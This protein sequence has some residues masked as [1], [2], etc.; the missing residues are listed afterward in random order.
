MV[1]CRVR[2]VLACQP[3]L[4]PTTPPT[5]RAVLLGVSRL[6]LL[7]IFSTCLSRGIPTQLKEVLSTVG[8]TSEGANKYLLNGNK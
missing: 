4:S 7:R 8:G 5:G 1:K 3:A 6:I 2:T